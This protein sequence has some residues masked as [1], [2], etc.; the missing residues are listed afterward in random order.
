METPFGSHCFLVLKIVIEVAS[1]YPILMS[2]CTCVMLCIVKK[3]RFALEEM[4]S[5][6]E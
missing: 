6:F 4:N 5:T 2:S 1:A 3:K